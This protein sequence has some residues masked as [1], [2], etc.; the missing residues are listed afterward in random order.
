MGESMVE[1]QNMENK[2]GES[3][4]SLGVSVSFG[5]YENDALSWEKWSTFSPNKYLE[6]VGKCSTPGSVAQKKAFFEAHYKKIAAMKAEAEL[7]DQEKAAETDP[8]RSDDHTEYSFGEIKEELEDGTESKTHVYEEEEVQSDTLAMEGS[9]KGQEE[10]PD[11][12]QSHCAEEATSV[13]DESFRNGSGKGLEKKLD[14]NQSHCP[15]EVN[16]VKDE[17]FRD[18]SGKR[19]AEKPDSDQSQTTS[20]N[21]ESF[22]DGSMQMGNALEF[23]HLLSSQSPIAL[24][25]N[26]DKLAEATS[27]NEE[28]MKLVKQHFHVDSEIEEVQQSKQ[29]TPMPKAQN[30]AGNESMKLVKQHF[31]VDSEIEEIQESEHEIPKPKAQNLAGKVNPAKVEKNFVGTKKKPSSPIPK[32]PG[33]SVTKLSKPKATP[34][35][36]PAARSSSKKANAPSS[37]KSKTPSVSEGIRVAPK[38]LHLSMSM[39]SVNSDTASSVTSSRR[40]S[41][42]MEQMG[43]KDIVK[44]AFK[45]FQNRVNQLPSSDGRSSGPKQIR[46]TGLEQKASTSMTSQKEN[47]RS[48]KAAEKMNPA[49]GR[50]GPTWKSVSSGSLKGVNV[51]ERRQK[52]APSSVDL[53]SNERAERRKEFFK[54][55]EEK[56]NAREAERTQLGS[57]SKELKDAEMKKLRQNLNFKAKPMPSFYRAQGVSK[58]TSEKF[59]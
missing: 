40:R 16:S 15:E 49:R 5:K 35:P 26:A 39:S 8:S 30:L 3:V 28:S 22:V 53:R 47:E 36:M 52:V 34:T 55:L 21:N 25:S 33:T 31:R 29:E 45:T 20:V 54:N 11:S 50:L 12:N 58:S 38:S 48:R 41:L 2:M 27:V 6:E 13:K 43:D 24:Y 10:K 9:G 37:S 14:S 17:S 46:T 32:P 57:K 56:S 4:S 44:R 51:D 19:Q 59:C 18:G 7:L 42:F 23:Q 1:A